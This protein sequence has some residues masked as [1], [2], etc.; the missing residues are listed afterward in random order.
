MLLISF[1]SNNFLS[2]LMSE[3]ILTSVWVVKSEERSVK[4]SSE[5]DFEKFD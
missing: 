3:K 1:S 2:V 5:A 4:S